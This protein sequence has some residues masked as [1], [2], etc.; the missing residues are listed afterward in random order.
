MW[1]FKNLAKYFIQ[2][3]NTDKSCFP[4]VEAGNLEM[5]DILI[6]SCDLYQNM[7]KY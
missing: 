5:I 3:S 6:L 7:N 4:H 1:I 2:K